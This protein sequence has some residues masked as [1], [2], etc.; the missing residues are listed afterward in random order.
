MP[1]TIQEIISDV[2]PLGS[3]SSILDELNHLI[4][5]PNTT[6]HQIEGVLQKDTNLAMKLL[7]IANSSFYGHATRID[8]ISQ[9]LVMVGMNQVMD[10]LTGS[11]VIDHFKGVESKYLDMNR[12]WQHSIGTGLA[13]KGISEQLGNSDIEASFVAGMLHDVGRLILCMNAPEQMAQAFQKTESGSISLMAAENQVFGFNHADVGMAL[14][15]QWKFPQN[16]V[17]A[18]GFHHQPSHSQ[19]SRRPATIIHLADGMS[20]VLNFGDGG[21]EKYCYFYEPGSW[22]MLGIP[23]VKVEAILEKTDRNF[24]SIFKLYF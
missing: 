3:L 10:L 23:T 2:K 7:K 12:F 18:A 19:F 4:R 5:D 17:E 16:I 1:Q 24:D 22:E 8:K 20:H 9:A 14:F 11:F 21:G 15:Q 13:A 6:I